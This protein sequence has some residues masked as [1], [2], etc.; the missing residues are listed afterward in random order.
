M[1]ETTPDIRT[2]NRTDYRVHGRQPHRWVSSLAIH[3][4]CFAEIRSAFSS[5]ICFWSAS[6]AN[7]E[8]GECPSPRSVLLCVVASRRNPGR[9][10]RVMDL[11]LPAIAI[12]PREEA[13]RSQSP[14]GEGSS[15][16]SRAPRSRK[17]TSRSG[18]EL[19]FCDR[20]QRGPALWDYGIP[21]SRPLTR[22]IMHEH[23]RETPPHRH[24]NNTCGFSPG[25]HRRPV[26]D[27]CPIR[28]SIRYFLPRACRVKAP[29]A[30]LANER[31]ESSVITSLSIRGRGFS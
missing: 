10:S 23:V 5:V 31:G 24:E 1:T 6:S 18:T 11:F 17:F 14:M 13:T 20:M 25:R 3:G 9:I 29:S 12:R 27:P 8:G 21:F 19:E 30:S 22:A 16:M 28:K 15:R 2:R 7:E 26:G 4:G